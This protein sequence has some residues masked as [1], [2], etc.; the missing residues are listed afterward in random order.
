[1]LQ[2]AGYIKMK[3]IK[4]KG[5]VKMQETA[6]MLLAVVMLFII[7]GLFF[8]VIRYRNL[9]KTA[10]LF[11]KEKALSTVARIADTAEFS[12][13]EPLCIDTDKL[14]VMNNREAYAEFWP[15]TSLSVRK[16][17]QEGEIE[18]NKVNYPDCNFF[19]IYG[20]EEAETLATFVSL[21]RKEKDEN[22]GYWYDK[23]E[24]GK[25]IA[26]FEIKQP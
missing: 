4:K 15:V 21:C 1:V 23:C 14:I 3:K 9:Y 19:K 12:C 7:A 2:I 20:G 8:I 5:Q 26:G 16:L 25:I 10:N 22:T 17:S 24:L 6:F 13:G 11:E 18:C